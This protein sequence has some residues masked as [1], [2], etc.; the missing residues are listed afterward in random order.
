MNDYAGWVQRAFKFTQHLPSSKKMLGKI[1][2]NAT[3]A[4][5]LTQEE[6]EQIKT[7]VQKA[8]PE[9]LCRFWL[10]GSRCCSFRYVIE[11]NV[12]SYE[13]DDT[14]YGGVSF[15][16]PAELTGHIESCLDGAEGAEDVPDQMPFWKNSIPFAALDN[17]DYLGVLVTD[18]EV[19]QPVVC[20]SHDDESSI[21]APSFSSFLLTWERLCYIGPEIW[22]IEK[23]LDDKGLLDAETEQAQSLR[24]IFDD[25]KPLHAPQALEDFA[26]EVLLERRIS[27]M[28]QVCA[29]AVM[30]ISDEDGKLPDADRWQEQLQNYGSDIKRISKLPGVP[31]SVCAMNSKLSGIQESS[32]ANPEK[33]V[34]FFESHLNGDN[35]SGTQADVLNH[36]Q[37]EGQ[38]IFVLADSRVGIFNQSMQQELKWTAE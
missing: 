14:L 7:D 20:L 34:L 26:P 36:K 22:V 37:R 24:D 11:R 25:R 18:D 12:A 9:E 15:F 5:P 29:S 31:V 21:L 10:E 19:K 38:I 28:K 13:N 30:F 17:G 35:P 4:P 23:Y 3:V 8:L 16:D 33:T 6:L 2:A 1:T 32:I 27:F